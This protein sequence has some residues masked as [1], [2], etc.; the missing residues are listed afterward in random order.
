[1]ADDLP[2]RVGD[3]LRE[4][5]ETLAVAESLTGGL[6]GARLT[7]VPGASDYFDRSLA[8][9]AYDAK[10]QQLAVS[11]ESLDAHG[12]VSAAVAREMAQ[13]VRDV[14]DADWGLSATGIAGPGG[15]SEGKP[16]GLVYV[17]LA[18]AADWGTEDS[19]ARAARF[20]FDGDREAVRER[21]VDAA[22]EE[23]LAAIREVE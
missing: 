15:G 19:F 12:A 10:R 18:H 14:A 8:T 22:L 21:S 9:Y 13:G 17:G 6:I 5:A 16:V 3:R 7:A 4:R 23:L 20:E 11:R 1:M 2:E